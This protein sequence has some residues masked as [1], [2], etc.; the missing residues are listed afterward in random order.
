[1]H[2]QASMLHVHLQMTVCISHASLCLD[3]GITY[4]WAYLFSI[5]L[6]WELNAAGEASQAHLH[7]AGF[8]EPNHLHAQTCCCHDQC[9]FNVTYMACTAAEQELVCFL[10]SG[11]AFMQI[12]M[13]HKGCQ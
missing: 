4:A 6:R 7:C 8:L 12:S 9:K 11:R 2:R 10:A 5:A 13:Q 1:M 3:M